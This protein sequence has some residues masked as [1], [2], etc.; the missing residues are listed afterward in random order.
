MDSSSMIIAH[1]RP[2]G[3]RGMREPLWD[4][5]HRPPGV[6]EADPA[7]GGGSLANLELGLVGSPRRLGDGQIRGSAGE[8][9]A[10]G[11]SGCRDEGGL[12]L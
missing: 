4:V 8:Q 6:G 11:G 5:G 7:S 1:R 10:A 2:R 12:S 3:S 9:V